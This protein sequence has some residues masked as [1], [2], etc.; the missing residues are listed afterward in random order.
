MLRR[1]VAVVLLLSVVPM[2][3]RAQT[4]AVS[5]SPS[6]PEILA[7]VE[8]YLRNLFAWGPDFQVKVGPLAESPAP[9][10]YDVPVQVTYKHRTDS[11]TV[12][13]TKD[14]KFVF[15]GEIHDINSDPF[16]AVRAK[17]N[18][19]SSPSTG[20]SNAAVT[21]VEYSDYQCPHCRELYRTLKEIEPRYPQVR[22]V[23]KD[24]PLTQ[25]H[26]W[27]MTAAIGARC[28]YQQSPDAFFTVQSAIFES[29]DLLSAENAWDKILEFAARA[30][31]PA[32]SYRAC[33]ASPE[34]KAAVEADLAEGQA[35]KI[36]STPTLFVNGRETVGG[37]KDTLE[38]LIDYELAHLTHKPSRQP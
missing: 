2:L 4:P 12:Y 32:D 29:Q 20:P 9:E 35:L 18:L 21:L 17:I 26:P 14:G 3:A 28:A 1:F 37:E 24:F 31:V 25:I 27:A 33:M 16:A 11:G 19:N 10:F 22:F 30:G 34:T 8:K 6:Q 13:V 38:Q 7:N 15:R 23:F 36:S 5:R